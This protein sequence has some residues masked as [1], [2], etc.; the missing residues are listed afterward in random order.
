MADKP[1]F[2]ITSI[3][4]F[5]AIDEN[6]EEGVCAFQTDSGGWMPM[7]AGDEVRAGQLRPLA[8]QIAEVTGRPVTEKRYVLVT[9]P[10]GPNWKGDA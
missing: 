3:V 7:V 5:T 8:A 10:T 4:A 1:G 9:G 6:D 2:R